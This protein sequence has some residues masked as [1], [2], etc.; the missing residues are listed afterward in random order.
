MHLNRLRDIKAIKEDEFIFS[1]V[2]A[3][4]SDSEDESEGEGSKEEESKK[5]VIAAF[6]MDSRVKDGR[7]ALLY[8]DTTDKPQVWFQ[9]LSCNWFFIANTFTDYFRLMI[10]HVGLPHWQYAFTQV[11]L[12][13]QTL[14]W[15]RF[16]CPERLAIDMENRRNQELHA[17]RKHRGDK[18]V[19]SGY[20]GDKIKIES[21]R[22]KKRRMKLKNKGTSDN[23]IEK[24]SATSSKSAKF[25]RAK[26]KGSKNKIKK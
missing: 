12:D 10:M 3:E 1:S 19:K 16:L 8:K 6:D 15:F 23:I 21:L 25:A 5:P 26:V 17:K 24:F 18:G 7:L 2:G 13:P 22:R 11:G 9:D 20:T 14:Q 4:Y